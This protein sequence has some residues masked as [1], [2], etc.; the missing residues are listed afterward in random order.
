M[1]VQEPTPTQVVLRCRHCQRPLEGRAVYC[2][3]LCIELDDGRAAVLAAQLAAMQKW[4]DEQAAA[5]DAE[6][7]RIAFEKRR[8]LAGTKADLD[9][10][11]ANLAPLAANLSAAKAAGEIRFSLSSDA[12]FESGWR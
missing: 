6:L 12:P 4:Y 1:A 11:T 10:M 3:T 9:V 8:V 5:V 7:A 2:S